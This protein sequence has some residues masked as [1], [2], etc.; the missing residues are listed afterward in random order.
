MKFLNNHS[1]LAR[2]FLLSA[3]LAFGV[4]AQAQTQTQADPLPSWNDGQAKQ[5]IVNFVKETTDQAS[6]KFVPPVDRIA[7][8]DQLHADHVHQTDRRGRSQASPCL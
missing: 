3:L 2:V 7:T 6:P 4:H 1:C 8:F 5:A